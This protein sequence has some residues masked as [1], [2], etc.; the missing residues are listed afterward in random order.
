MALEKSYE[1]KWR[2]R[3]GRDRTDLKQILVMEQLKPFQDW[4][5][6][7]MPEDD[8]WDELKYAL[9]VLYGTP[10]D[11]SLW[12]AFLNRSLQ[13]SERAFKEKLFNKG[14]GREIR[15]PANR[16][17]ATSAREYARALSGKKFDTEALLTVADDTLTYLAIDDVPWEEIEQAKCLNA[18]RAVLVA[19][20]AQRAQEIFDLYDTYP[21][22]KQEA[23]LLKDLVEAALK[24]DGTTPLKE[25][26]PLE[27]YDKFFD[28]VRSPGF[29]GGKS[30]C[31]PGH[32]RFEIGVI[33]H[34]WFFS[35]DG[36]IDWQQV[37]EDI[38]R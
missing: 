32:L 21:V 12:S 6:N 19:G 35:K 29:K 36:S 18:V 8:A 25:S 24:A 11:K 16:S 3:I 38:R 1:I 33:R 22:D 23:S 10:S 30:F 15:Y 26:I 37:I 14:P 28:R 20:D 9:D 4:D 27:R 7:M 34:R 17:K 31:D 13:V 2:E 5:R